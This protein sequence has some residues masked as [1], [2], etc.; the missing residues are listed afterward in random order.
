MDGGLS[1]NIP[2]LNEE[3]I[4]VSPFAGESDICPKDDSA[5]PFHVY[6][7]NTSMQFTMGNL[8]RMSRALF[9]PHPEI[10]SDMCQQ[11]FDDCLKFLQNNSKY[12]RYSKACL[13]GPLKRNQKLVFKN[14]YRLM[15]VK[16]IAECSKRAFCNTFDLH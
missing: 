7:A 8:Y 6:L 4:T 16:S 15:Q 10:L 1:D 3:T 5:N 13:K 2:R 12:I 11:G 9:P 14:D